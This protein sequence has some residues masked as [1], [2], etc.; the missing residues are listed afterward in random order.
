MRFVYCAVASC[1][2]LQDYQSIN[3]PKLVRYIMHSFVRFVSSFLKLKNY[4]QKVFSRCK[5]PPLIE[6][7]QIEKTFCFLVQKSLLLVRH[8]TNMN[9]S[10]DL[11]IPNFIDALL[12]QGYC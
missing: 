1:Y 2:I 11:L 4:Y 10:A 6:L 8:A 12:G 3:V 5:N 7:K 9:L